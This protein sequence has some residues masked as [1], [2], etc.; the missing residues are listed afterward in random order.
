MTVCLNSKA[1]N[2]FTSQCS[3]P[4]QLNKTMKTTEE[5]VAELLSITTELQK[6]SVWGQMQQY[7]I[8]MKKFFDGIQMEAYT[9][10]FSDGVKQKEIDLSRQN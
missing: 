8:Q 7:P 6:L 10:G 5:L 4:I 9:K 1:N 2:G 3:E